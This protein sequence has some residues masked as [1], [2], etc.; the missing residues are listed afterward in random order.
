M[1]EFKL[2]G[3]TSSKQVEHAKNKLYKKYGKASQRT[4]RIKVFENLSTSKLTHL[5]YL[6]TNKFVNVYYNVVSDI[7][8]IVDESRNTLI[9]FGV[10]SKALYAQVFSTKALLDRKDWGRIVEDA[11][12]IEQQLESSLQNSPSAI[13]KYQP[14]VMPYYEARSI[15]NNAYGDIEVEIAN[16]EFTMNGQQNAKKLIHGSD[17]G[18]DLQNSGFSQ[19]EA[20]KINKLSIIEYVAQSG[21]IPSVDL[22]RDYINSSKIFYE[23]NPRITRNDTVQF[24][25]EPMIAFYDPVTKQIVL[26][27]K[28]SKKF[29]T[30]YRLS[31]IQSQRYADSGAAG[32]EKLSKVG[33]VD[34]E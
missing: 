29:R 16:R 9:E 34:D 6:S 1:V 17:F 20:K 3:S 18:L 21:K 30:A 12:Q 14:R 25:D 2:S 22:V 28:E 4:L 32:R 8:A 11:R 31:A 19:A 27:E 5:P 15:L 33:K 26:F 24:R 7:F 23:D 13:S 10:R